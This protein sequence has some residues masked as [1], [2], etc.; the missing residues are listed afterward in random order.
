MDMEDKC[1]TCLN[2]SRLGF[3]DVFAFCIVDGMEIEADVILCENYDH[4]D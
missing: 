3:G 4:E 1:K 2:N